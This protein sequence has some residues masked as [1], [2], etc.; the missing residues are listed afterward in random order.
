MA[1]DVFSAKKLEREVLIDPRA[2]GIVVIDMLNEFCKPGGAMIL[3]G[4]VRL[5]P[6][7]PRVIDAGPTAGTPN[8][9]QRLT[10]SQPTPEPS[11][12]ARMSPP[13][14]STARR[15]RTASRRESEPSPGPGP[16]AVRPH[17]FTHKGDEAMWSVRTT[18]RPFSPSRRRWVQGAAASTAALGLGLPH[19]GRAADSIKVGVLQPLSGGLENLGQ[20]GVQGTQLAIEEA[21]DAGGVLGRRLEPVIADDKTDP[22]TAVERTRELI[23][24]DQ[25]VAIFGP[26]TSA[27]RD[28]I[29]PTSDRFKTQL[30]YAND[31]AGGVCDRHI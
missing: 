6:P 11:S 31:D 9:T 15:A 10:T 14:C 28:A 16:A 22:K 4:S 7:Q 2:T 23:Q 29:Q 17:A 13:R 20:Q 25:V 8:R 12:I 24:R 5:V 19:I 21:N 30:V 18:A 3:P 27:N 1:V 26:G